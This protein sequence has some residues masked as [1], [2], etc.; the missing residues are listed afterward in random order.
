MFLDTIVSTDLLQIKPTE[1]SGIESFIGQ[2]KV[3]W[4]SGRACF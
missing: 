3:N 4:K 1:E 2:P